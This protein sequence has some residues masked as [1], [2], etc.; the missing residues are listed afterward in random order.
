[1]TIKKAEEK[2]IPLIK[3]LAEKSWRANYPGII[4]DEQIDYMLEIM[5]SEKA[6]S[7]DFENKNYK[8]YLINSA[9]NTAVGIL[10]FETCYEKNTTKLHRIYLLKETKGKGFGKF[11][12]EFLK[13][14]IKKTDNSRIILNVNKENPAIKFYESQ[15]FETYREGTFDIGNGFVMDD[16]LMEFKF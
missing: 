9:E 13:S 4:S 11:A 12:V 2:D 8:Y 5:Y 14:E 15:G 7:K 16:F 3:S 10:G 1:M 6:L